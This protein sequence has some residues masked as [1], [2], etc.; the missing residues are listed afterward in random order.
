MRALLVEDD[1]MIGRAIEHAL[2]DA[3]YAVDWV[4]DG[5]SAVASSETESYD[6]VLLDLGIPRL[7]GLGVLQRFRKRQRRCL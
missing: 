4:M 3:A 7:D 2:R 1:R 6:I 5:E